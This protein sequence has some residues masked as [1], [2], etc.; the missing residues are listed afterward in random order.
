M[1][2]EGVGVVAE[3]DGGKWER[4][5]DFEGKEDLEMEGQRE[6]G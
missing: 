1:Q 3:I 5:V 4:N 2:R 6:V